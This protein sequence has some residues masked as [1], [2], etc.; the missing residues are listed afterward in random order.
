MEAVLG[1]V[2]ANDDIAG[3]LHDASGGVPEAAKMLL[4]LVASGGLLRRH[5]QWVCDRTT[6]DAT[7][8]TLPADV[9]LPTIDDS[10]RSSSSGSA[11]RSMRSRQKTSSV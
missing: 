8:R 1:P 3:R 6:W 10:Q 5:Q 11:S 9:V 7:L 4:A 2:S